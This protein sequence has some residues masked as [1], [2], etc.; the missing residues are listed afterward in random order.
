MKL[1]KLISLMVSAIMLVLTIASCGA[2]G[3]ISASVTILG[4]DGET[5][6][7]K[8]TVKLDNGMRYDEALV[9]AVEGL[10]GCEYDYPAGG[11]FKS[12]TIFGETYAQDA[13][14]EDGA[15]YYWG[16]ETL[17]GKT[18]AEAVDQS[19]EGSESAED[20]SADSANL[21]FALS[22][23]VV[24]GD[25]IVFRYMAT[26]STKATI[27][28]YNENGDAI[29]ESASVDVKEYGKNLSI[30]QIVKNAC[31]AENIECAISSDGKSIKN[32]TSDCVTLDN[33]TQT[34]YFV[35]QD[36]KTNKEVTKIKAGDNIKVVY[37]V[38]V[39]E[40]APGA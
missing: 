34:S 6:V 2:G 3:K 35:F 19:A 4:K 1:T 36:A 22:D 37:K 7:E 13:K 39:K 16:I 15:V 21:G 26:D 14:D 12:I 31:D 24:D 10:S 30:A 8:T 32:I 9:I 18:E 28:I 40:I 33:D 5:L 38:E 25:D 17:N 23:K 27:S 29:I 11:E 20:Q